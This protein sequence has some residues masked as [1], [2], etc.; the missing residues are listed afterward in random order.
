MHRPIFNFIYTSC[1]ILF[2]AC[3]QYCSVIA[4]SLPD[5]S[6]LSSDNEEDAGVMTEEYQGA[7]LKS[8]EHAS[9]R[10]IS[11]SIYNMNM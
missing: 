1:N 9:I 6:T 7:I 4:E 5:V 8:Y 11:V 3:S 10:Y 2:Y